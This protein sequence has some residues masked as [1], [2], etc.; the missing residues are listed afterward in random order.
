[1]NDTSGRS[2]VG[3]G[4]FGAEFEAGVRRI[5]QAEMVRVLRRVLGDLTA[6]VACEDHES[7]GGAAR[8]SPIAAP[9]LGTS[10]RTVTVVTNK[11][12][13]AVKKKPETAKAA[14]AKKASAPKKKAAAPKPK[15][16][17]KPPAAKLSADEVNAR[18]LAVLTGEPQRSEDI[19]REARLDKWI[20]Q[21]GTRKLVASG[22]LVKEGSK[23]TTT[24]RL[25][26]PLREGLANGA[27]SG[28][29]PTS[30][31]GE[32]VSQ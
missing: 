26:E 21:E 11:K 13:A 30:T 18:I 32:H 3:A 19:R 24:F 25:P 2:N 8:P 28:A 1:M 20:F 23:R 15:T 22:S 10:T 12:P 9:K 14:P 27:P 5:A 29:L 4:V 31:T 17:P 7:Q 16:P 6:L